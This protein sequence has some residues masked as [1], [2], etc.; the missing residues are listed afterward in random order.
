MPA[1]ALRPAAQGAEC[2]RRSTTKGRAWRRLASDAPEQCS[3]RRWQRD[4]AT[5]AVDRNERCS[6]AHE[7]M[8]IVQSRDQVVECDATRAH[9]GK[10]RAN[11]NH[12]VVASGG[13]EACG[14][15]GDC[16]PHACT[17]H[18]GVA[19]S[20]RANEICPAHLAPN[21]IICVIHDAHLIRLGV[22]NTKVDIVKER[23]RRVS[24]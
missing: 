13:M 3:H 23:R 21:Q 4:R 6:R 16:Q 9:L 22:A 19:H 24:W 8:A 2:N 14:Q 20:A 10:R 12:V 7:P 1:R 17:F 18:V 5:R 15:L 11:A